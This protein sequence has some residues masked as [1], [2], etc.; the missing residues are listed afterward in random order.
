MC[1]GLGKLNSKQGS[2]AQLVR[3][4]LALFTPAE[5]QLPVQNPQFRLRSRGG[6][7]AESVHVQEESH[8]YLLLF[9]NKGSN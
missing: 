9:Q 3:T 7:E 2:D 6:G 5:Q 8:M 4:G 1:W